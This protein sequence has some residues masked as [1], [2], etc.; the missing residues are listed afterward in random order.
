VDRT[1]TILAQVESVHAELDE[2]AGLRTGRA[3]LA[4]LLLDALAETLAEPEWPV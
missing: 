3:R 1:E 2:L 4:A